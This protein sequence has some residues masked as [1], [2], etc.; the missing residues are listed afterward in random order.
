[1]LQSTPD[2]WLVGGRKESTAPLRLFAFPYAGGSA[3]AF[4]QWHK[5]MPPNID[6]FA[7]QLP[8]R[9]MRFSE[10]KLT[11]FVTAMEAIV[12]ALRPHLNQPFAFFGHSL[13]AWLAFESVRCLRRMGGPAPV[14]LFLSGGSA[15]QVQDPIPGYNRFSDAEFIKSVTRYGG[16]A[17]ELLENKDLMDLFLPTLR[18]D[19]SLLETYKYFEEPPLDCPIS[20]FGG[21]DDPEAPR[22]KLAAW[23]I[24]TTKTF[25]ISMFPGN[26]FYLNQHQA[27]LTG[28][29]IR[30]LDRT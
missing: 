5:S 14:H 18:A 30:A 1:M 27:A 7:L 8:G 17:E 23:N 12:T 21:L 3:S 10:P 20:V 15:P 9:E 24:H 22:A 4:R 28:E 19:F 29:I 25:R 26:H 13:G 6:F 16:M 11:Y 2:R